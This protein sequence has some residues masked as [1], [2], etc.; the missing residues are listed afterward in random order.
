MDAR[1]KLIQKRG[2][3]AIR[4]RAR[5]EGTAERPRLSVFR[6]N[7]FMLAQL[8]DDVAGKTLASATSKSMKTKG[9]KTAGAE[10]VGKTI[11]EKAKAAGIKAAVFDR[12]SYRYHGRVKALVEA[13]RKE[14][15]NI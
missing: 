5:I 3:R 12:G 13:I 6:S 14:G 7:R 4:V 8:I 2:R 1:K 9:T 10:F 11:A 15:V